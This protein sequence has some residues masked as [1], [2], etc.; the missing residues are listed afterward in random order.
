MQPRVGAL[1]MLSRVT[2]A[3]MMSE[4][5]LLLLDRYEVLGTIRRGPT[6]VMLLT[7]DRRLGRRVVVELL[8]LPTNGFT[9]LRDAADRLMRQTRMAAALSHPNLSAIHD[10]CQ[11]GATM[12]VVSEFDSGR[13]LAQRL[14]DEGP[15]PLEAALDAVRQVASALAFAHAHGL[16]H[17]G[18]DPTQVVEG[19]DGRMKIRNLGRAGAAVPP[20]RYVAPETILRQPASEATDVW[21]LG[22][23][24]YETLTGRP[25][26]DGESADLCARVV[27]DVPVRPRRVR[28][29][30]C[31]ALENVILT[32]LEKE[33]GLR[34]P[35]VSAFLQ[36][37]DNARQ[38]STPRFDLPALS[39]HRQSRR[40][41]MAWMLLLVVLTVSAWL[42]SAVRA[43]QSRRPFAPR[44]TQGAPMVDNP[45][46]RA[47]TD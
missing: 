21:A 2:S 35:S 30:I 1:G 20:P 28:P 4:N 11:S 24:L 38:K 18:L 13:T 39:K 9:V 31:P 33:P 42:L 3:M 16:L 29:D 10:V 43:L 5:E 12:V 14:R 6:A 22:V 17:R 45:G 47:P 32:C 26:F 8:A 7:Y 41:L 46:P 23:L 40:P 37:L 36:S 19:V 34:Y 15:L 27:R 25:P 44:P